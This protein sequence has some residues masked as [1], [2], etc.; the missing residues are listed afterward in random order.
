MNRVPKIIPISKLRQTQKDVLAELSETPV[1]LTQHG[2]A[3]AVLVDR[4]Q[5]NQLL[6]ELED[7]RDSYEALEERY[8]IA[9]GQEEVDVYVHQSDRVG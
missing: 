3:V 6:E 8:K 4:S 2:E 5:W 7:W 9:V 1:V